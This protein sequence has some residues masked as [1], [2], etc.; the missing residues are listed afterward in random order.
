MVCLGVR[1]GDAAV[2]SAG[3]CVKYSGFDRGTPSES[4][5]TFLG[6]TIP[7]GTAHRHSMPG[8]RYASTHPSAAADESSAR[9]AAALPPST[10]IFRNMLLSAALQT[11]RSFPEILA[12]KRRYS[13]H[14][15]ENK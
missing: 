12:M 6:V 7:R 1:A 8:Y 11:C 3:N 4:R 14:P 10:P 2:G 13:V 15:P 9:N 5:E